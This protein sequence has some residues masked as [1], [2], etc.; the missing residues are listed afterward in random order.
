MQVASQAA[1]GATQSSEGASNAKSEACADDDNRDQA[2][3]A[4]D[5]SSYRE[6]PCSGFDWFGTG[7]REEAEAAKWSDSVSELTKCCMLGVA[8]FLMPPVLGRVVRLWM[9]G[10]VALKLVENIAESVNGP[11]KGPSK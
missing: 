9:Y 4:A 10:A 6:R 7:E 1:S 3:N 2:F 11:G 8:S 5:I